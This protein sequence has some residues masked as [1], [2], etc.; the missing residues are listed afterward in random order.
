MVVK[1]ADYHV[2]VKMYRLSLRMLNSSDLLSC[3]TISDFVS[4]VQ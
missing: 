3:C 2:P 4:G 1:A